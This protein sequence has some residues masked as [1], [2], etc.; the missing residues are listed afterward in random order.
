MAWY[1]TFFEGVPQRAWKLGQSEEQTEFEAEFLWDVLELET[2]NAVLDVFS[3]YGRHAIQLAG[4][5]AELWCVDISREYCE[6]LTVTSREENLGIQVLCADFLEAVLPPKKMDAAYCM[7]NSLS[8]FDRENMKVFFTRI[9][10]S[11]SAGGRLVLHTSMLAESILP[12]FQDN[13]WMEVGDGEE[14][15]YYLVQNEY[16]V[17]EGVIHARITY[18]EK[19]ETSVYPIEQHLYT[20]SELRKI[21]LGAGFTVQEVFSAIDGEPYRLGDEEAFILLKKD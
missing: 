5:G 17:L 21:A 6:E 4:K 8:F 14:R 10:D 7:G 3:G 15:I 12:A 18:V 9:A 20:L 16:D 2:G 13:A 11:L 19:G 1:H